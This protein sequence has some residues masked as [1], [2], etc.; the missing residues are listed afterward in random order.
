MREIKSDKRV[1]G[2][3]DLF[4][5]LRGIWVQRWLVLIVSATITLMSGAYAFLSAPIYEVRANV[6]PPEK[7]DVDSFNF[8]RLIGVGS[9]FDLAKTVDGALSLDTY[10]VKGVFGAFIRN[11]QSESL[12]HKF[13]IE[14]Y[15]PSLSEAERKK[16]EGL[17]YR[18]FS[19]SLSIVP[20]KEIVDKLTIVTQTGHPAETA[21]WLYRFVEQVGTATK[22]NLLKSFSA[23]IN[24]RIQ[25]IDSE[26]A[27][28]RKNAAV[29]RQNSV[30]RLRDA[31]KVARAIGLD[32][33]VIISGSVSKDL[34][35]TIDPSLIYLRGAKALEAEVENLEAR[36]S[37]DSYIRD[38][39]KLQ[40]LSEFY[41]SILLKPQ[42]IAVYR[43]DGDIV[44]PD[45]PIKPRKTLI[46]LMGLAM[47]LMFGIILGVIRHFWTGRI[48]GDLTS[49]TEGQK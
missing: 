17:L 16:P 38:L 14:V 44:L 2:E 10:S 40:G 27:M 43:L 39:P 5:F 11:L 20:P 8:N 29:E 4:D 47:G 3:V 34:S 13:F 35:G 37:D 24:M 6:L 42:D 1:S 28:L 49:A 21:D 15:L 25:N 19:E 23:E 9:K 22:E 41:K 46:I 31:L 26:I 45:S 30:V 36:E 18:Q 32:N 48:T 33:Q 7:N 12:R